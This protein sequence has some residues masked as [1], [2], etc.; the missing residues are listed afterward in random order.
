M[1]PDVLFSLFIER[2]A[3][4]G[5]GLESEAAMQAL[6]AFIVTTNDEDATKVLATG[7]AG[8]ATLPKDQ[9]G[10][11]RIVNPW[12]GIPDILAIAKDC[13]VIH[14]D[15]PVG[16][17]HTNDAYYAA[18]IQEQG[19]SPYYNHKNGSTCSDK[20]PP[21]GGGWVDELKAPPEAEAEFQKRI[22]ATLAALK[23]RKG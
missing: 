14:Q 23:A 13:G 18:E 9:E 15:Y 8:I 12:R 3:R 19:W 16:V 1:K 21:Q 10:F 4:L 22:D 5:I 2:L 17:S 7:A 11:F 20:K 6:M